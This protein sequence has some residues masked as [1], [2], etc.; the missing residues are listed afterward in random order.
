MKKLNA[1]VV[2]CGA[3]HRNHAD[4]IA[5]CPEVRLYAV[6]DIK[7]DRAVEAAGRYNC[8]Y[9]T[10]F[11]EMLECKEID[12][13][14]LCTPHYLHAPMAVEAMRKGKHVLTEKP[15]AMTPE[16]AG[17]MI[18]VSEETG[19]VLGVCFQNRY[20]AVSVRIKELLDSGVAG[21]VLG[22]K[23]S[24]TWCRDEK[25]Y[26]GSGWRGKWS[27]EGGGVLINQAIH[28]LDL[29]QWFLGEIESIRANVDTRL[30]EGIIE[31]EDTAEAMIKFS[32][33]AAA[34]FYATNNYPINS[35]IEIEIICENAVMKL[36]DNLT[37]KY[38]DGREETVSENE[39]KTG[40]KAYWGLSHRYLI[41]DYYEK[42]LKNEKFELNGYE[43]I[44][45]LKIIRGIYE[46][47]NEQKKLVPLK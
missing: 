24:V 22:A 30:L 8:K 44:K 35:P 16:E 26:T 14:H 45:A 47:S 4:A 20:N 32:S 46:S 27:T 13:I 15:M 6:C 40:E 31:V 10:D 37:V 38:K 5:D 12:V 28:T 9:Y 19:K 2:G 3:I 41:Q 33:G 36:V 17:E 25:Y 29:L 42:L 1:A 34:L 39:R 7:E 23:A 11:K 43:G 18:K 21:K